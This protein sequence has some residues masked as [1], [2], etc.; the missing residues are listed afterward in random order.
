MGSREVQRRF[1]KNGGL[2]KD[3]NLTFNVKRGLYINFEASSPAMTCFCVKLKNQG[4][5]ELD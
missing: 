3:K 2:L 4:S 5:D 1:P